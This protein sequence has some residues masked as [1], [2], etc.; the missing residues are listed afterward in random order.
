MLGFQ[1]IK[2]YLNG[3]RLNLTKHYCKFKNWCS[4]YAFTSEHDPQHYSVFLRFIEGLRP[5][6]TFVEGGFQ[7][8]QSFM[9]AHFQIIHLCANM[10]NNTIMFYNDI[11]KASRHNSNFVEEDF[12][13]QQSFMFAHYQIILSCANI[14]HKIIKFCGD[15]WRATSYIQ[16]LLKRASSLNSLSCLPIYKLYIRTLTW[17]TS[18]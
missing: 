2:S 13:P 3:W 9:V 8:Q 17:S 18:Q 15:L 6:W 7:P 14:I 12:Q 10:I 5:Y 11:W 16:H 4:I 1:P